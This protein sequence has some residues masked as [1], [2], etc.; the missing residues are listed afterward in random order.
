MTV[1]KAQAQQLVLDLPFDTALGEDDFVVSS[2]NLKAYE[3]LIG[4]REWPGPTALLIGPQKSGKTHLASIWASQAGAEVLTANKP[5]AWPQMMHGPILVEDCHRLWMGET[6]LFNLLNQAMRSQLPLLMTA[7]RPIDQWGLQT[8]D[9]RSRLRLALNLEIAPLDDA[10]LAQL[11]VKLFDD[12]Q[13]Q[14]DP[15]LIPYLLSRME[16]APA[17]VVSLVEMMDQMSLE[18]K[19][20]ISKRLAGEALAKLYNQ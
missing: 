2:G 4:M 5:D 17:H 9:V 3:Y 19:R 14:I 15:G 13:L 7:D 16:R 6:P 10:H 20:P 1:Q 8:Q 12:R 11:F 18:R